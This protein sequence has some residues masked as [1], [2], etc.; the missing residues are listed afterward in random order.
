MPLLFDA[1]S[2]FQSPVNLDSTRKQGAF[3]PKLLDPWETE[4]SL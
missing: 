4:F 3:A 2:V 1:D